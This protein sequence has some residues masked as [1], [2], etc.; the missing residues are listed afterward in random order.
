MAKMTPFSHCL[1]TI[2]FAATCSVSMLT[3]GAT[4]DSSSSPNDARVPNMDVFA[5]Q[6]QTRRVFPECGVQDSL[7]CASDLYLDVRTTGGALPVPA[8]HPSLALLPP[9]LLSSVLFDLQQ[10][11]SECPI[12]ELDAALEEAQAKSHEYGRVGYATAS[13]KL[14][15]CFGIVSPAAQSR[16]L[17]FLIWSDGVIY[18][19]VDCPIRFGRSAVCRL[20]LYP[21]AQAA[22]GLRETI[23]GFDVH[24]LTLLL[25]HVYEVGSRI[26]NLISAYGEPLLPPDIREF[27][28]EALRLAALSER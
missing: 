3:S 12:V 23:D 1:A 2:A 27:D 6:V 14:S 10:H 26:S 28:A 19:W 24:S 4:A 18:G 15:A 5:A 11:P 22:L 8:Q 13:A 9:P 17:V 16:P 25:T 7:T 21:L 20:E